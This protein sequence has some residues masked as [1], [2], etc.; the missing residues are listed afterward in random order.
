VEERPRNREAE[1]D[2]L[3]IAVEEELAV[4]PPMPPSQQQPRQ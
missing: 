1:V 3:A 4:R 2:V